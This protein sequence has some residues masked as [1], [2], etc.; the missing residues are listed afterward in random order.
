MPYQQQTAPVIDWY[1]RS[2]ARVVSIDAV[3]SL[4]DVGQRALLALR[5]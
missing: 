5:S 3:G 2:G 4:D 1:R